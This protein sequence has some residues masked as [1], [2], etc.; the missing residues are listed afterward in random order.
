MERLPLS[1]NLSRRDTVLERSEVN[2]ILSE[3][4]ARLLEVRTIPG[5]ET[6][7]FGFVARLCAIGHLDAEAFWMVLALTSGDLRYITEA[8]SQLGKARNRSKQAQQQ[9]TERVLRRLSSHF[10]ELTD[11]IIQ[12]RHITAQIENGKPHEHPRQSNRIPVPASRLND[13]L[14]DRNALAEMV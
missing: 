7:A 2:A 4:A 5:E 6:K 1:P 12:I 9:A 13:A 3:V 14:D 10:P 11:V 8:Y